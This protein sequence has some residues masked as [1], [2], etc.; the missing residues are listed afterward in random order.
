[1]YHTHTFTPAQVKALSITGYIV[2]VRHDGEIYQGKVSC[3]EGDTWTTV[4]LDDG[5]C[6]VDFDCTPIERLEPSVAYQWTTPWG[7]T[8]TAWARL[9]QVRRGVSLAKRDK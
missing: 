1:M 8:I 9:S 5:T 7:D 4:A 2:T 6:V 3:V